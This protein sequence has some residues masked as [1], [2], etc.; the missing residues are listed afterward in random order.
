MCAFA[1]QAL[2]GA[3]PSATVMRRSGK[4]GARYVLDRLAEI[5]TTATFEGRPRRGSRTSFA[6][7]ARD[8]RARH[9]RPRPAPR[10]DA[11]LVSKP[12]H[13][14]RT[15][16]ARSPGRARACRLWGGP[17]ELGVTRLGL[18]GS[19]SGVELDPARRF[20]IVPWLGAA[21]PALGFAVIAHATALALA[22]RGH[23]WRLARPIRRPPLRGPGCPRGLASRRRG[24]RRRPPRRRRVALGH[25]ARRPGSSRLDRRSRSRRGGA[26]AR[27]CVIR[28]DTPGCRFH[29]VPFE[30]RSSPGPIRRPH[31]RGGRPS[32]APRP[33]MAG[34]GLRRARG[35]RPGRL[36]PRRSCRR[37]CAARR[38]LR[39]GRRQGGK[40]STN[41]TLFDSSSV[42]SCS[43][44]GPPGAGAR[45]PVTRTR[46]D[47][48]SAL[49]DR[50]CERPGS[51]RSRPS[52][53]TGTWRTTAS[54]DTC[55]TPT[56]SRRSGFT[57]HAD[58]GTSHGCAS[59]SSGRPRGHGDGDLC[60]DERPARRR[61][62]PTAVVRRPGARDRHP[63]TAIARVRSSRLRPLSH[64]DSAEGPGPPSTSSAAAS[65]AA[66]ATSPR[67]T[68]CRASPPGT[69]RP[70]R[71]TASC[72]GRR[73]TPA[74]R[75][76]FWA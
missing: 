44:R 72:P 7:D 52:A 21:V 25:P 68:W 65:C 38:G 23:R 30:A 47:G 34:L 3:R 27:L 69:S 57:P 13:R 4:P 24:R 60:L 46:G 51:T 28:L 41:T 1:S 40:T 73:S 5:G 33:P 55:A 43:P 35:G 61:A 76:D 8:R 37:A 48:G 16:A 70:A 32:R 45:R 53:A 2:L 19:R 12:A 64:L 71:I 42:P 29:P 9:P 18:P 59:W 56:R 49:R 62:P 26:T 10:Y 17:R 63:R 39:R 58:S 75:T 67:P 6:L 15:G 14:A 54:N 20:T 36:A 22:G 74:S 50:P 66:R 11:P 31:P